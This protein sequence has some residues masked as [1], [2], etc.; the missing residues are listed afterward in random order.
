MLSQFKG[1]IKA[2]ERESAKPLPVFIVV[3]EDGESRTM[4]A[5]DIELYLAEYEA[6][7]DGVKPIGEYQQISGTLPAGEAWATFYSR[8]STHTKG[9][10]ERNDSPKL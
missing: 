3:F 10:G 6:G 7:K 2:L 8:L 4:D 1:R 9:G 5:L